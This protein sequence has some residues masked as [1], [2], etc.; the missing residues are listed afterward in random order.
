[1]KNSRKLLTLALCGLM[2]L[3]ATVGTGC[4]PKIVEKIDADKTQIYVSLYNGG[5]GT[6]WFEELRTEW[7]ANNDKYEVIPKEDKLDA[8]G[9]I[10]NIEGPQS[11]TSPSIYF[12]IG[13]SEVK[14]LVET[15]KL[16]DLS[17]FVNTTKPDG[18]NGLTIRQKLDSR[19]GYFETWSS[20]AGH[21][22]KDGSLYM[23]PWNDSVHGFIYDHDSALDPNGDGSYDDTYLYKAENTDAVK[24]ALTEQGI[25][26]E[27][28]GQNLIFVSATGKTNYKENG[29]ILRAG[30]DGK[31]GTYDDGQPITMEEWNNMAY[32][33]NNILGKKVFMWTGAFPEYT[34]HI[35]NALI[36]Q[37]SGLQSV[38]DLYDHDSNGV[39]YEMN[40]GSQQ[41][42]DI[43]NGYKSF[44]MMGI[45]KA[46]EFVYNNLCNTSYLHP[47]WDKTAYDHAATQGF[48]LMGY[49]GGET[50]PETA[51]IIEGSWWENEARTYFKSNADNGD[52]DRGFGKRDYRYMLTP[53][54]EGGVGP[55]GNGKGT[56]MG[57]SEVSSVLVTKQTDADKLAAI[58]D[59][60]AFTLKEENL[61]KY[62]VK[63]GVIRPY[64]YNLTEEDRNNMTPFANNNWDL[65]KDSENIALV[66][67]TLIECQPIVYATSGMSAFPNIGYT[68]NVK[69][70]YSNMYLVLNSIKVPA[71]ENAAEYKINT[72][73]NYIANAYPE[74]EWTK[75][76]NQAK[77]NGFYK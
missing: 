44:S 6:Q 59:F 68:N 61:R 32:T 51:M 19:E 47:N 25:T 20:V 42:F 55:F 38:I 7:N 10:T 26:F 67:S 30:K 12:S 18:E 33:I 22:S 72:F 15:R 1:M 29:L 74:T 56:A 3:G 2:T 58:K 40:D 49:R 14:K 60:L 50:N 54:F 69:M 43:N 66:S 39:A 11:A 70:T 41:A 21:S 76:L 57:L 8:A 17:D 73:T 63:T 35:E 62:T 16:E 24:A 4:G 34:R 31:Y 77:E 64:V 71:G 75:L 23:L 48:F 5:L 45:N 37:Y 53:D 65:Y 52:A 13:T 27:V 46:V 36:A 28:E 9:V